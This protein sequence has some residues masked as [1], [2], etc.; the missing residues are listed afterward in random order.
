MRGVARARERGERQLVPCVE[1]ELPRHRVGEVAVRL[2][3]QEQVA[4]RVA[5][6]QVRELILV[7]AFA[8]VARLDLARIRE[9]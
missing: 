3:D 6:A 1:Q 7:A 9:P 2:L 8:G 5:V 4:E